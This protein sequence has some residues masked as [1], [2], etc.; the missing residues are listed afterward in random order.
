MDFLKIQLS[1][2]AYVRKVEAVVKARLDRRN[3]R[4]M[5]IEHQKTNPINNGATVRVCRALLMAH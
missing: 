3:A 2:H 4:G 5:N 1:D